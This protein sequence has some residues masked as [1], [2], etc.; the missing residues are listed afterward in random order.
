MARAR[1]G[2]P[3]EGGRRIRIKADD[4]MYQLVEWTPRTLERVK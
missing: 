4:T 1:F 3:Q 2:D